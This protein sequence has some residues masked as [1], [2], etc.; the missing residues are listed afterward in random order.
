MYGTMYGKMFYKLSRDKTTANKKPQ[1]LKDLSRK[2]TMTG[3]DPV[4][5]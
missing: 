1:Y 4:I 2:K 5:L 3:G